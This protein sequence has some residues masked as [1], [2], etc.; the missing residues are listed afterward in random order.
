M[1]TQ[2]IFKPCLGDAG[3]ATVAA[4]TLL[5][6]VLTFMIGVL[7]FAASLALEARATT[8]CRSAMLE[9]QTQAARALRELLALNARAQKLEFARI[10]AGRALLAA[11]A[12]SNPLAIAAARV[13]MVSIERSQRILR[14]QQL[15]WLNAG[16]L[17]SRLTVTNS[18][19]AIRQAIPSSL[20]RILAPKNQLE[21]QAAFQNSLWVQHPK[22]QVVAI[23]PTARTP[24]YKPAPGFQIH[25]EGVIQWTL[26]LTK[27][28]KV[29]LGCAVSL[30]SGNGLDWSPA[31][32]EDKL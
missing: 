32:T 5:P 25:Q 16:K 26:P 20:L 2:M 29:R 23:P 9:S 21:H 3:Q 30:F 13:A 4:L 1:K 17:A 19:S 15:Y 10:S 7:V 31:P 28:I 12:T 8:A 22:F 27:R 24:V 14:R 11:F 18:L 6:V